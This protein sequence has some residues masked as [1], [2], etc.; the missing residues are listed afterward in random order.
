MAAL[1]LN[2]LHAGDTVVQWNESG[3]NQMRG[4]LGGTTNWPQMDSYAMMLGGQQEMGVDLRDSQIGVS[5]AYWLWGDAVE[6]GG[7]FWNMA[8]G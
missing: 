5:M 3:T 2:A 4:W 7:L 6:L 8:L 1:G